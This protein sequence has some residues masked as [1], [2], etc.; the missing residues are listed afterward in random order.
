M[1]FMK[2]FLLTGEFDRT[3][4]ALGCYDSLDKAQGAV[5]GILECRPLVHGEHDVQYPINNI[6][7][8]AKRSNGDLYVVREFLLN[9]FR[10]SPG[11]GAGLH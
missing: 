3:T 6:V 11:L 4:D 2:I 10:L 5:T 9:E 1:P 8:V 7:S